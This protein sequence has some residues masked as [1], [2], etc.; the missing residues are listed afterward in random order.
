MVNFN[1]C[2][3]YGITNKK[4]LSELLHIELKKLKNI[5]NHYTTYPF[6]KKSPNGKK[7]RILYNPHPEY[8]KVLK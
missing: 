3:L 2:K 8:K 1:D 5:E 6:Y 4:Y 7:T